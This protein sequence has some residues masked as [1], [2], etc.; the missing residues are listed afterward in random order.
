MLSTAAR[1]CGQSSRRRGRARSAAAARTAAGR[2]RRDD[3]SRTR[4]AGKT[5]TVSSAAAAARGGGIAEG[6]EGAIR[7]AGGRRGRQRKAGGR[8]DARADRTPQ[9]EGGSAASRK[10]KR[11]EALEGGPRVFVA[12]LFSRCDFIAPPVRDPDHDPCQTHT[13]VLGLP[14]AHFPSKIRG[15]FLDLPKSGLERLSS[16]ASR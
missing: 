13:L 12:D 6:T 2:S 8:A 5:G 11:V 16:S 9:R 10:W 3:P 7:R 1:R 4:G 14:F 15:F